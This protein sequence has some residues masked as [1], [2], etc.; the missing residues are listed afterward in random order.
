V[1][2]AFYEKL[3][4][5]SQIV[6]AIL[7]IIVL[8]YLWQRFLA[9]A[10]VASQARKNA[11]LLEAEASRDA[12]KAEI[13]VAQNEAAAADADVRAITERGRA[14]AER[15]RERILNDGRAESERTLRNAD[16][17]L[18]RGRAAARERLRDDLLQKAIAIARRAAADVD[19][20]T[21]RRLV[22]EAVDRVDPGGRG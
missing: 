4:V 12:A 9:P 3:A 5:G 22:S 14:E 19:D 21:N 2:D 10:V 16:G 1:S 6:A 20:T 15:T 13:G 8:V 17:E 11:E 18:E 7:F